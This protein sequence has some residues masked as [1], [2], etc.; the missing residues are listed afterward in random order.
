MMKSVPIVLVLIFLTGCRRLPDNRVA[1]LAASTPSQIIIFSDPAL[2]KEALYSQLQEW[3]YVGYQLGGLSKKG[4]DC[5]GFVYL[6]YLS[7][8]G[9]RLPR[10]TDLQSTSGLSVAR[11]ELIV[12]DLVFFKTGFFTK[13]VG[14]YIEDGKFIHVSTQRGVVISRLDDHYWSRKYWKAVRVTT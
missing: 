2:V 6:T 3:K 7:E 10:T 4:I 8:F 1:P 13:H 5:S 11:K 12:G 9:I 14:I